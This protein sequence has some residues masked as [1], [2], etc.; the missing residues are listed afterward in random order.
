M[1]IKLS[2]TVIETVRNS[3]VSSKHSLRLQ[4]VRTTDE[5]QKEI[6]E[7]QLKEVEEALFV[8]DIME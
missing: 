3:L 8:F 4:L 2:E 7:H 6:L 1:E 5:T